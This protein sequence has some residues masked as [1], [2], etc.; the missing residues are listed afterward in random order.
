MHIKNNIE[1]WFAA[2]NI[3]YLL[4]NT[5]T[6]MTVTTTRKYRCYIDAC[7]WTHQ[8]FFILGRKFWLELPQAKFT[9]TFPSFLQTACSKQHTVDP[10]LQSIQGCNTEYKIHSVCPR[11]ICGSNEVHI[12]IYTW[13]ETRKT[14]PPL[15][16]RRCNLKNNFHPFCNSVPSKISYRFTVKFNKK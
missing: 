15:T 3:Q 8:F 6:Y 9:S 2:G 1:L 11:Y 7:R 10:T 4:G 16:A 12:H 13:L 5:Y 14:P